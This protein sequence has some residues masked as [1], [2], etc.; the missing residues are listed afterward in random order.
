MWSLVA[1]IAS[2]AV[3][4]VVLSVTQ[5]WAGGALRHRASRCTLAGIVSTT[6]LTLLML[7]LIGFHGELPSAHQNVAW[8]AIGLAVL[9]TAVVFTLGNRRRPITHVPDSALLQRTWAFLPANI[10]LVAALGAVDMFILSLV[11]LRNIH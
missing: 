9:T 11:F 1:P 3:A 10:A 7:F 6:T 4:S 5:A 8:S 2:I